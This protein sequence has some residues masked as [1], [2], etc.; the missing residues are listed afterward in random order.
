MHLT[1]N[2]E[3]WEMKDG[4]TAEELVRAFGAAERR[5]AVLR[6]GEVVPSAERASTVLE[7]GDGVEILVFAGGG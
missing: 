5:V 3:S 2:G 6:N 1:V 7:D 4:A